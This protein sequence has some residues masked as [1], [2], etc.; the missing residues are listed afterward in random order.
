[1]A[2]RTNPPRQLNTPDGLYAT[3][4]RVTSE[5]GPG[6][7]FAFGRVP[8]HSTGH[9]AGDDN[10]K[11]FA[12]Q[13]LALH[14]LH[15]M[16]P[17]DWLEKG[18]RKQGVDQLSPLERIVAAAMDYTGEQYSLFKKSFFSTWTAH[19]KPDGRS[20]KDRNEWARWVGA[21]SIR[22]HRI[23]KSERFVDMLHEL[24]LL[25]PGWWKQVYAQSHNTI[26]PDIVYDSPWD[27]QPSQSSLPLDLTTNSAPTPFTN[28]FAPVAGYSTT[29]TNN[30]S[31]IA[32]HTTHT[33][34]MAPRAYHATMA[35]A[36]G[37]GQP[38]STTPGDA[39]TSARG[40]GDNDTSA[41][42]TP[43]DFD[44][45]SQAS[46]TPAQFN[47]SYME[48]FNQVI[49][50]PSPAAVP[51]GPEVPPRQPQNN[52][53][54]PPAYMASPTYTMAAV[55][56]HQYTFST[57]PTGF[58]LVPEFPG[59]W[60]AADEREFARLVQARERA[61]C[62][63]ALYAELSGAAAATNIS[64]AQGAGP[65]PP[66]SHTAAQAGPGAGP[67]A[68]PSARPAPP[69]NQTVY[70]NTGDTIRYRQPP[71]PD[72][73]PRRWDFSR[74]LMDRLEEGDDWFQ[75]IHENPHES[76]PVAPFASH[77][78]NM[79]SDPRADVERR[80]AERRAAMSIAARTGFSSE[81]PVAG[82]V[83]RALPDVLNPEMAYTYDD[84][85]E[86]EE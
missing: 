29:V 83:P 52:V 86:D 55:S 73:D 15:V 21:N 75:Y 65:A 33:P 30:F 16:R 66:A 46:M 13:V 71:R 12:Q 53:D 58:V 81:T 69:V 31:P 35:G 28:N 57:A 50:D 64:S 18:V 34:A 17:Q 19:L 42:E 59:C 6:D 68:G 40:H 44:N 38:D 2:P 72:L 63:N 78:Q 39:T 5:L 61:Q 41:I 62:H 82:L 7:L 20:S 54:I 47:N 14:S 74:S 56:G 22:H 43:E 67:G 60:A 84:E 49:T 36:N 37:N 77:E 32:T 79:A 24:G 8:Q 4:V 9:W 10:V 26:I 85:E 23:G 51:S 70:G 76:D 48:F 25:Y 80:E 1:M 45:E 27:A 11:H 3:F